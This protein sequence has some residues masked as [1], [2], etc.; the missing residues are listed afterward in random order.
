MIVI[1]DIH[2]N[3]NTLQALL[4]QFPTGSEIALVGD[5]IDRGPDSKKVVQWAID[6]NIPTVTGNH[7]VMMV[8]DYDVIVSYIKHN[9]QMPFATSIWLMNGGYEALKSYCIFNENK[10]TDRGLPSFEFDFETFEK[11]AYWMNTLPTYLEF[12]IEDKDGRKLVISHSSIN[13]VWKHKDN[14][15]RAQAFKQNVTWGR[16]STIQDVPEIYNI[17]GHTPI[18]NGPKIKVPFA[19]VDTGAFYMREKGYGQLTGLDFP[20]MKVYQQPNIETVIYG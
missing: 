19:N 16:P 14:P 18:Q 3:F 12:D 20:T 7:E 11:H 5:L 13:G 4:A 1:G 9:N 6:N 2:G 17:F 15:D 10:L 8:D